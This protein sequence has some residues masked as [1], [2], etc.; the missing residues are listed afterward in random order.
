LKK[1][2]LTVPLTLGRKDS[3]SCGNLVDNLLRL[4]VV[5]SADGVRSEKV[6]IIKSAL[7]DGTYNVNAEDLAG[8][9]IK[10]VIA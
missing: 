8:R 10:R 5:N 4:V 3:V 1:S 7:T 2:K 6:A 9:I